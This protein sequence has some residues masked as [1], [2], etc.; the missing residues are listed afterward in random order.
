[1]KLKSLIAFAVVGAIA[2]SMSAADY[3]LAYKA[4]GKVKGYFANSTG[5]TYVKGSGKDRGYLVVGMSE[6]IGG[7]PTCR[8]GDAMFLFTDKKTKVATQEFTNIQIL[9]RY[10]AKGNY[11]FGAAYNI[12]IPVADPHAGQTGIPAT[13]V[14]GANGTPSGSSDFFTG[15]TK[16]AFVGLTAEKDVAKKMVGQFNEA[17]DGEVFASAKMN[18]S[19]DK[20]QTIAINTSASGA[21][22]ANISDAV[23]ALEKS[24]VEKGWTTR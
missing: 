16:L 15:T 17:F 14:T 5:N 8:L 18:Y 12:D 20:K 4:K 10:G 7:L 3:Y 21:P 6:L 1:M 9:Q 2:S 24:L 19:L 13:A 22:P 23:T 11:A